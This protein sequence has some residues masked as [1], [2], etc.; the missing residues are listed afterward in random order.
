MDI[1]F[2]GDYENC[3]SRTMDL[4]NPKVHKFMQGQECEPWPEMQAV[5]DAMRAVEELQQF[6]ACDCEA[7]SHA[8]EGEG[9][10]EC[11]DD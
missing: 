8:D 2:K 10:E 3:L 7:C 1:V 5:L 9:D 6:Q 11:D 4:R